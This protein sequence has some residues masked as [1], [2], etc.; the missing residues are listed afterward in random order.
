MLSRMDTVGS[1]QTLADAAQLVARGAN[2]L[3]VVDDE[4]RPVG[5]VT[6]D[7]LA[8]ALAESGPRASIAFASCA[9]V[10]AVAPSASADEVLAQLR[11]HPDSV[12]MVV[13]HGDA[14]GMITVDQLDHYLAS[15]D[16]T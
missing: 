7:A 2:S 6:R 1:G 14:V 9:N 8:H 4:G 5:V 11:A 3:P 13:D 10:V 16:R 12:A 15:L